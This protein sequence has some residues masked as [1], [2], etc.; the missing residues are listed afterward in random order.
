MLRKGLPKANIAFISI[1]PSPLRKK[2]L[3]EIKQA[4]EQIRQF[5]K[6]QRNATYIDVFSGMLDEQGAPRSALFRPDSLHMNEQGY[7]EWATIVKKY[8]K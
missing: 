2:Y 1:K 8:L 3:S 5:L 4:N 6:K 7:Q